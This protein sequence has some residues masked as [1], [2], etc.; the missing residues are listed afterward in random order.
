M[1]QMKKDKEEQLNPLEHFAAGLIKSTAGK[2]DEGKTK[3]KIIKNIKK[4]NVLKKDELIGANS[5]YNNYIS[6]N[7][8]ILN[9][10]GTKKITRYRKIPRKGDEFQNPSPNLLCSLSKNI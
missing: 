10:K 7:E 3:N 6:K 5:K 9:K 8:K 1:P 2:K 4:N